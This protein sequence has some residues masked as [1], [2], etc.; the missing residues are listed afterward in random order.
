MAEVMLR[1]RRLGDSG[2]WYTVVWTR[3]VPRGVQSQHCRAGRLDSRLVVCTVAVRGQQ[4]A[5]NFR[6][7][8]LALPCFA[9]AAPGLLVVKF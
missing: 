5:D 6:A 9:F 8:E 4:A 2:T 1:K 3:A 7:A